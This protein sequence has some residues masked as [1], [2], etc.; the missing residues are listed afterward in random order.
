MTLHV[1]SARISYRGE[2]RLDVTR[3]SGQEGLFL[4][5]SWKILRPAI[6]ARKRAAAL[7]MEDAIVPALAERKVAW[8]RYVPAYLEEMRAS[9]R[10]ELAAWNALLARERVVLVC[11][12]VDAEHCHR[13]LLRTQILPK[14]GAVDGGEL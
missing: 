4:A 11:Y 14:L 8:D 2:D 7:A 9:Y 6:A 10:R 1:Y 13:Y 3:K 5:P 12:C